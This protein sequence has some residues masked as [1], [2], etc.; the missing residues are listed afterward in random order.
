M[1]YAIEKNQDLLDEI[2]RLSDAVVRLQRNEEHYK[3]ICGSFSRVLAYL[4]FSNP[5]TVEGWRM[6]KETEALL[7]EHADG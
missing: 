3:A 1:A 6:V 7:A 5:L 4:K 2:E